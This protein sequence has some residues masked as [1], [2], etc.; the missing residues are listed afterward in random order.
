MNLAYL[1][2]WRRFCLFKTIQLATFFK[3]IFMAGVLKTVVGKTA[4]YGTLG[5]GVGTGW[6]ALI[7]FMY[8]RQAT[9]ERG[10]SAATD[11][12]TGLLSLKDR[13]Q[14][15]K[16]IWGSTD[17]GCGVTAKVANG[18]AELKRSIP[19][20][21]TLTSQA[22]NF[23]AEHLPNGVLQPV[24]DAMQGLVPHTVHAQGVA[25]VAS[26]LDLTGAYTTLAVR[27]GDVLATGPICGATSR[28]MKPL[29]N[30]AMTAAPSNTA[31]LFAYG[32]A[33]VLTVVVV[34]G[35]VGRQGP[36]RRQSATVKNTPA[37]QPQP[38][39]TA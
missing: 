5:A 23:L 19:D 24:T 15:L 30:Q 3:R 4:K 37:T 18:A 8:A 39:V 11:Q 14:P 10:M 26:R 6:V 34:A 1:P 16:N 12:L 21:S 20:N 29:M 31:E 35:T 25:E 27:C 7:E 17:T 32:L 22:H 13:C 9:F 2:A 33:A 28:A 38:V 36:R